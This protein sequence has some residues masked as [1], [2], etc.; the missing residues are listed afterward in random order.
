[1]SLPWL[2]LANPM[3]KQQQK[4]NIQPGS[5]K[6]SLNYA[7]EQKVHQVQEDVFFSGAAAPRRF[8]RP[9]GGESPPPRPPLQQLRR[10]GGGWRRTSPSPSPLLG[11]GASGSMLRRNLRSLGVLETP[12]PPFKPTPLRSIGTAAL[13]NSR[14]ESKGMACRFWMI[15]LVACLEG[16]LKCQDSL[17]QHLLQGIVCCTQQ[18]LGLHI[19]HC[20]E[21]NQLVGLVAFTA[22]IWKVS[23][24]ESKECCKILCVIN[25]SQIGFKTNTHHDGPIGSFPILCHGLVTDHPQINTHREN[26]KWSFI[27][28]VS[29]NCVMHKSQISHK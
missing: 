29:K 25:K 26:L 22:Q 10:P 23:G 6:F 9:R 27:L 2:F 8:R 21:R 15:I 24:K 12:L 19:R 14:R 1:M 13:C 28:A 16:V 11:A 20:P 18:D 7:Q 4:H 3:S 5:T 17:E